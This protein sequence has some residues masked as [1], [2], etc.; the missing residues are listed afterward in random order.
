MGMGYGANYA[1]TIDI[2][3][4]KQLAPRAWAKLE[5]LWQEDQLVGDN[6]L[7]VFHHLVNEDAYGY[8]QVE[9]DLMAGTPL[10]EGDTWEARTE[11]YKKAWDALAAEFR[12]VTFQQSGSALE[13]GIGY[14]NADDEGDR[15]DEVDGVYFTVGGVWE[16]TPAGKTF[17][18]IIE[19]KFYV[20]FG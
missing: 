14:H 4:V 10:S 11:V 3:N 8:E 5:E 7:R 6:A 15:Y 13:L 16:R 9:T 20:T 17:E 2:E 12:V 18:S 1:D 19:R